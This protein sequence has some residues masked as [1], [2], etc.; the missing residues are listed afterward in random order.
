MRHLLSLPILLMSFTS[1]HA[2]LPDTQAPQNTYPSSNQGITHTSSPPAYAP[3]RILVKFRPGTAASE[4]GGLM[5]VSHAKSLKVIS[6]IDVHVLQVPAGT[7]KTQLARL[8]Q[9]PNVLYAEPDLNRITSVHYFPNEGDSDNIYA[10]DYFSEQWALNNDGQTHTVVVNDPIF[11]QSLEAT[12]GLPDADI[13][14]PEAWGM[15]QGNPSVKIAI[16]DSG[17][18]C[19][20]AGDSVSSIEFGN[21]K[22]VEQQKFVTDY[23]SD[24]LEDVI[25]HGT[26]VAG[27]AAGQTDNGIGISGV[28][29]NSSI[30]NLKACYEYLIYTCDPFLGCILT[31]AMG[32]CPLSSSI[33]AITY[34]ADNGYQVINMSY[35]SD[36]IDADSNPISLVGYSQAEND[37]VNYAWDKGVLLVG[38]AGNGGDTI[39]SYPAAY[40]N[41][42]AV[43]ATD[44]DDN[45]ASFST[46]GSGWVSLMAPGDNI[47][48]TIPNDLC[49]SFD[50]DNDACL[51]WQSGTSMASPH[52]AGVAALLWAYKYA[53]QLFDPATCQDASGVACNQM[54]RM[55]LEQGADS[56]G[57]NGQNLEAISQYGRLNAAGALTST[58][59]TQLPPSFVKAPD[60]LSIAVNSNIVSLGWTYAGDVDGTAGFKLERENWNAKRNRWQSL[61]SWEVLDPT[62]TTFDDSSASGEVHYRVGA[63]Q[64]SD[65]SVFWSDW[66]INVTVA[67]KGGGK[68]GGKPK[69]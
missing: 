44:D 26:H 24:T 38:A 35:A 20:M 49:G 8:S 21:G 3:D 46:Y 51:H 15:T 40:D 64:Q 29:F 16:L 27:I 1:L 6:G 18:D 62:A 34:A 39:K 56:I 50:Y 13:D 67:S 42:I 11:G 28:G 9:N 19:R 63:I 54:I 61:T 23:Q 69:K 68:G 57:A 12:S 2:A 25:G 32:V 33:D 53:D 7:V 47:L 30:G 17:I 22:C 52:V 10:S 37:A 66:T 41:V 59:S 5:R 65:G 58:P 4:V 48:S 43:G 36:E 14:A 55:M 60:N 31:T 45:R